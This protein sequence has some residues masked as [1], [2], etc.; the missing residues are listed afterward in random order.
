[1]LFSFL[2]FHPF[3]FRSKISFIHFS[4]H[5]LCPLFVT[6]CYPVSASLI[7]QILFD[8]IQFPRLLSFR[9]Q[10]SQTQSSII[11]NMLLSSFCI[12]HPSK[13]YDMLC[14]QYSRHTMLKN[15]LLHFNFF[16][17][18]VASASAGLNS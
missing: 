5:T 2:V 6:C 14:V 9:F 10:S 8:S 15:Q 11:C 1:M 16:L 7:F 18:N 13:I 12:F 4:R 17:I 3:I